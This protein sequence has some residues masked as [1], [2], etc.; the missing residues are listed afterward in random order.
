M[1][2]KGYSKIELIDALINEIDNMNKMLKIPKWIK[3]YKGGI[4]DEKEFND[5]LSFVAKNAID[6]A[7]TGTNPRISTQEE[8]EKLLLCVYYDRQVDF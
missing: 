8:I 7:W 4:I 2:L 1:G 6:D 3:D 5:K